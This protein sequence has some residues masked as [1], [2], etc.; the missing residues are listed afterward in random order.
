[1]WF[2]SAARVFSGKTS[3]LVTFGQSRSGFLQIHAKHTPDLRTLQRLA[4]LQGLILHTLLA[5]SDHGGCKAEAEYDQM[6]ARRR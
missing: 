5:S 2:N 4:H 1:M 3:K 6:L